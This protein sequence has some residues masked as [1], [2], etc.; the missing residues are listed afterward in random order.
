MEPILNKQEIAELLLAIRSGQIPLDTPEGR[1][2]ERLQNALEIDL[3]N[4]ERKQSEESR[5]PNFDLILDNFCM[6]YTI[7]LTNELQRN[8]T[9]T[10]NTI[11][12]FEFQKFVADMGEPGAIGILNMPPLK[13]G[14][15]FITDLPFSYA[16]I[17]IMLG[18]S[19]DIE[20]KPP[21]RQLTTLELTMMRPLMELSCGCFDKTFKP[22]INIETHL[23]KIDSS[24][25]LVSVTEPDS[26][27]LTSKLTVNLK[28]GSGEITLA[29]PVTTLAPI[30]EKLHGLLNMD[31]MTK[32]SW[33]AILQ[34]SIQKME[35]HLTAQSGTMDL[36]V[37]QIANLREGDILPLDYDPNGPLRILVGDQLKYFAKPGTHRGKK[38][39]SITSVYDN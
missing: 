20:A 15:L 36:T 38:A 21:E 26:E 17:E 19:P 10:R 13:Q 5:F 34:K 31:E 8:F 29:F 6:N 25:R 4:L 23:H 27:V 12:A 7:A 24:P 37:G 39:I 14:V 16:M 18:A 11:E 1:R 9:I 35:M 30:R 22:L 33:R 2:Q 3:F 28:G 32:G